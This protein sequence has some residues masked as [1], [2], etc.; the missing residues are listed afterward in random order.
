LKDTVLDLYGAS[1]LTDCVQRSGGFSDPQGGCI[2]SALRSL[3]P[4]SS[5]VSL[6]LLIREGPNDPWSEITWQQS[7]S[8][9]E[10]GV[11]VVGRKMCH[12]AAEDLTSSCIA[13]A[14]IDSL[15]RLPTEWTLSNTSTGY[16]ASC[17]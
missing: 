8:L 3:S 12:P 9:L 5:D 16:F 1:T 2:D 6:D 17:C 7:S 11:S 4:K 15:H 13:D 14:K 10:T